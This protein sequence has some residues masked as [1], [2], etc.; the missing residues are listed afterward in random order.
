MLLWQ[1]SRSRLFM[2]YNILLKDV[3]NGQSPVDAFPRNANLHMFR[4]R[5]SQLWN[6]AGLYSQH[7]KTACFHKALSNYYNFLD[8]VGKIMSFV[9]VGGFLNKTGVH[10]HSYLIYSWITWIGKYPGV[11]PC[12]ELNQPSL[13]WKER[14]IKYEQQFEIFLCLAFKLQFGVV[15]PICWRDI[16]LENT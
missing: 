7:F 9:V 6:Y 14:G 5:R 16:D 15:E 8:R 3:N 1:N 10:A 2:W 12:L 11:C 4:L 13:Y